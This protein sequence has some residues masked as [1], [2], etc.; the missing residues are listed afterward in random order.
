MLAV[1]ED[2]DDLGPALGLSDRDVSHG[3]RALADDHVLL[4]FIDVEGDELRKGL[5]QLDL[6]AAIDVAR[7]EELD[8]D[9]VAVI[10]LGNDLL[11]FEQVVLVRSKPEAGSRRGRREDRAEKSDNGHAGLHR[12]PCFGRPAIRPE[13]DHLMGKKA[14]RPDRRL[15]SPCLPALAVLAPARKSPAPIRRQSRSYLCD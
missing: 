1:Q 12:Q 7:L 14:I 4:L 9:E 13:R 8:D 5:L 2:D 10:A 15:L 6:V 3:A 11:I